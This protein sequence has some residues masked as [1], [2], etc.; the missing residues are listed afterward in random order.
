VGGYPTEKPV[1]LADIL[2]GQSSDPGETV[3]DP[4]LGSGAFGV[5]ALRAGRRFLG[6][7]TS[8]TALNWA[9]PRL[10]SV[11]DAET[12]VQSPAIAPW[13]S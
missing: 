10:C 4:F 2:V 7:D 11:G 3:A 13:P 1:A 6:A 12:A 8:E 5:A 9:R